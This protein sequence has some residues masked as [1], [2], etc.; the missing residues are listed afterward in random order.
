MDDLTSTSPTSKQVQVVVLY[1]SFDLDF[2]ILVCRRRC[3]AD[4]KELGECN[5]L[6]MDSSTW[7]TADEK[8][9]SQTKASLISSVAGGCGECL[10]GQGDFNL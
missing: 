10:E 7:P 9:T 3:V 1:L 5:D 8:N 2:L 6:V 4:D